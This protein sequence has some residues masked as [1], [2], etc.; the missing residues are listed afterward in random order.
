MR[1]S[2]SNAELKKYTFLFSHF[3]D[4]PDREMAGTRFSYYFDPVNET[5]YIDSVHEDAGSFHGS[6]RNLLRKTDRNNVL[7]KAKEYCPE[8]A[9]HIVLLCKKQSI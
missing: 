5:F 6:Y 8:Q 2:I 1:N 7:S 4:D 9:E 3:I